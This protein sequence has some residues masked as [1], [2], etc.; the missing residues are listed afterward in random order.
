MTASNSRIT[1]Q[2]VMKVIGKHMLPDVFSMILDLE[3]SQGNRI[4]D[5]LGGR[6]YLDCFTYIAS[7]PLGHNH[8]KMDDPSFEKKLLRAAKCKPSNSDL[9]TVEMAEYVE[10]LS[11]VAIPQELPHLFLI[12]GGTLAVE[13]ALKTAFDWKIRLNQSRGIAGE[14]GTQIIHLKEAFHGRSGYTLSLTNTAD[15]RK[16]KLFPK[17]DWPRVLNPKC[18]FPLEGTN[19][20]QTVRAEEQSLAEIQQ[21]IDQYGPDIAAIILEPI[22]GEGGDNQF[23]PEFH[24]ALRRVADAHDLLLIYDEVQTGVG[25]T[26]KMWAYQHYGI[27]PDILCFGKKMQL[28]GIL[29]GTRIDQVADNCFVERSRINSTW[30]GNLVDMVRAQKILEIIEEDRLVENAKETGGYLLASL[31]KLQSK[32]GGLVANVRGMGLMCA[33]DLPTTQRRDQLRESVYKNGA[34]VLGCGVQSMRFRPSL[35]F[36]T[37]EVDE[38]IGIFDHSLGEVS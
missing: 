2:Q 20:E 10:T 5:A 4:Y 16:T 29:C 13:N 33:F 36:S 12:E 18:V 15:P 31:L 19:L 1:P 17:F 21:A 8:P 9:Y 37:Q 25:L 30:G 26:G 24:Q 34:V 32:Y 27:F 22:Q 38:L 3:K 6:D 11:R 28:C 23:R 14:V 35:T 7:N